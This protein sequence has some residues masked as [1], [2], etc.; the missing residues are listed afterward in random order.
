MVEVRDGGCELRVGQ[1]GRHYLPPRHT[2]V[3]PEP[4]R[5]VCLRHTHTLVGVAEA[6][7][8]HHV[9]SRVGARRLAFQQ[10]HLRT[11]VGQAALFDLALTH[12]G[13]PLDALGADGVERLAVD[14]VLDGV[15]GA[16]V[17]LATHARLVVRFLVTRGFPFVEAQ[18]VGSGAVL[19]DDGT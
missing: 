19:G 3:L 5:G 1:I 15:R 8:R 16:D 10:S 14:R 7:A 2:T 4:A 18:G 17:P 13:E 12:A 9:T 11:Q 6:A